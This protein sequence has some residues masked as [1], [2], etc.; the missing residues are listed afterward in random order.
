MPFQS[1]S[2]TVCGRGP[3]GGRG[4]CRMLHSRREAGALPICPLGPPIHQHH[5]SSVSHATTK[6]DREE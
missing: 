6:S 3:Q 2:H 4:S 5:N 1:L